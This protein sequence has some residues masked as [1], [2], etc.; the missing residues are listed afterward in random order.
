[1]VSFHL[2]D[3]HLG[4]KVYGFSMIEDQKYILDEILRESVEHEID[5]IFIAGDVFDKGIPSVEA[6]GLFEY[7]LE[8]LRE[9]NIKIFMIAGNHDSAKR[10]SFGHNMFVKNQLYIGTEF[11]GKIEIF[12]T[13]DE[14]GKINIHL[15]P[16]IK[17][18]FCV[19][20]FDEKVETYEEMLQTVFKHH[21]LD[22]NQ[23]NI[24]LAHQ[25]VT[26]KGTAEESE[27]EI[28][29]IGGLDQVDASNFF[30][31]DYVALGHLHR[32]Q[33]I[34]KDYI[35]YAGSP[36]Q[37]SFSEP[38][39]KVITKIVLK[40]K[41]DLQLDLIP[42]KPFKVL[43]EIKGDLE[44][45]LQVG[46]EIGGSQDYIKVVLTDKIRPFDPLGKLRNIYP[47][48]MSLENINEEE[49]M[50]EKLE[51][52]PQQLN[53][54]N[55]FSQFFQERNLKDLTEEQMEIIEKM[56]DNLGGVEE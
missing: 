13:E 55:L 30:D 45:L 39:N 9:K 31:F 56:W 32:P 25:F 19:E 43:R 15:L 33:R 22:S 5:T 27:S 26:W 53:P 48:I 6:I 3:L 12:E 11:R 52:E 54:I 47:N 17:P 8:K 36:I 28:S 1:M 18:S 35:R 41:G 34:G 37:Y 16:F 42:L 23:R 49:K 29:S 2:G 38:N 44:N 40:E 4:K 51:F 20:Y 21:N 7:F 50:Y 46:K 14:F 10:L 24:L